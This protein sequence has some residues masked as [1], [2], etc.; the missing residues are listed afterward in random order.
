MARIID[1][2]RKWYPGTWTY[3]HRYCVYTLTT[4]TG[5]RTVRA[6]AEYAPR[7]DW[8]DDH[9]E[10]TYRWEDTGEHALGYELKLV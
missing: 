5:T 2:L 10:T 1:R 4:D 8:D 6:Y 7:Y 9:Y 3:S